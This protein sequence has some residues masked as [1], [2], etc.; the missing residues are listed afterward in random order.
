MLSQTPDETETVSNFSYWA[1]ELTLLC[2]RIGSRF[3][4][5][6]P[7]RQAAVYLKGLFAPIGRKNSWQLA[8]IAG[9]KTPDGI[10]RLL[11]TAVWD[12]DGVRDDLCDYVVAYMGDANGTLVIDETGFLKKG[13][14]SVG[15]KRQYSG[16]AGKVENCQIGVFLSYASRHGRTLLDRELYRPQAWADDED[17][18]R[19][20]HVPEAIRFQ[21]KPQLAKTMLKR[22]F[23]ARVPAQWIAG[24]TVYGG[25]RQLRAWLGS[26]K[27]AFVLAV[28][29]NEMLWFDRGQ[30]AQQCRADAIADAIQPDEWQRLSAGDGA[31]G[32]R[33]YDWARQPLDCEGKDP[34]WA[35]WLLA[36]RS[37]TDGERAFYV[38]FAPTQ[39]VLQTLVSVAGQRWTIEECIE[40]AKD[41]LGLDEY[42]VRTWQGWYRHITLV[43]LAQACLNVV[44]LQATAAEKKRGRPLA[45]HA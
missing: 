38:V 24:D 31:K 11:N 36:R 6:E 8:E 39:T 42:E 44:C 26:E 18:R 35:H 10:Q 20:A 21:T 33:L 22:A 4:R 16:T 41:E 2:H 5:A 27:R 45:E 13:N 32:P 15:V 37:I 25:D 43:M 1:A 23:A 34:D 40:I 9:E 19:E 3:A 17:R 12:V 30:G 14:K 29:V 7:R 28:A